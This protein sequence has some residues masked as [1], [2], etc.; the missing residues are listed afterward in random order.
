MQRSHKGR[1]RREA[2]GEGTADGARKRPAI[3]AKAGTYPIGG[4]KRRIPP[5]P[6]KG[7]GRRERGGRGYCG[8]GARAPSPPNPRRIV[9]PAK[10]GTYPI[11]AGAQAPPVI[12]AKA[13]ISPPLARQPFPLALIRRSFALK[14][15]SFSAHGAL[16]R[17]SKNAQTALIECSLPQDGAGWPPDPPALAPNSAKAAHRP[18]RREPVP[19][20]PQAA[21]VIMTQGHCA[22]LRPL[23]S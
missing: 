10:A 22:S 19:R 6:N 11:G 12:P 17:R 7:R 23:L 8:R 15:R 18:P 16:I 4:A 14:K 20:L 21:S 3:P 13:G 1:G 2:A 9:I 5:L